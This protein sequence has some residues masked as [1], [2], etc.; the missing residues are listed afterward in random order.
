[1]NDE[2]MVSVTEAALRTG[3]QKE[4]VRRYIAEGRLPAVKLPNGYYRVREQDLQRMLQPV[5]GKK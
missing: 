1:M 4:T 5:G 3:L 2:R